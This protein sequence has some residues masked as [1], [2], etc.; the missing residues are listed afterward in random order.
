[1]HGIKQVGFSTS[2][3]T[4]NTVRGGRK[5]MDFGLLFERPKV[6]DGDLFDVHDDGWMDGWIDESNLMQTRQPQ[7]ERAMKM[8]AGGFEKKYNEGRRRAAP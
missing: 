1:L 8:V 7:Q 3:A 2:I 6:G 4:H 5:R